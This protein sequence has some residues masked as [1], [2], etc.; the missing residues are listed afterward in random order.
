MA[1]AGGKIC[2]QLGEKEYQCESCQECRECLFPCNS[3]GASTDMKNL[4]T[5]GFLLC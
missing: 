3:A 2:V 4:M 5:Y 1:G